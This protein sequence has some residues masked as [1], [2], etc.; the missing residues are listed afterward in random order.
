MSEDVLDTVA[1]A[2]AA[3]FGFADAR[4]ERVTEGLINDTYLVRDAGTG[5]PLAVLQRL[6]PIFAPE[7]HH[8]IDAVTAH[9]AARGLDTPRLLRTRGGEHWVRL[10]GG[11]WRALTYVDGITRSRVENPAQARSAGELVGR[12]HAATADLD[13]AFSFS[14]PG[15]HDTSAHLARLRSAVGESRADELAEARALG[16]AILAR[17]EALPA[18]PELPSRIAHGDLK[19][20]NVVFFRDEPD[21]AR[22]LID[23]DTL[24]RQSIAFE[25][26]DAL[27]SWC[28]GGG[29]D[30]PGRAALDLE[31][32][33]AAL[34]GYAG[35]AGALLSATE[36]D[37]IVPGI[38]TICVE[39]AARFC[40]DAFEDQY[41]GWDPARYPS[42][43]EHNLARARGQLALSRSVNEQREAACKAAR[44]AFAD[45]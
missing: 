31:V 3:A 23:L 15:V 19:I 5:A 37:A 18:L 36:I 13:H 24:T 1:G 35:G 10:E 14:R 9:L 8:D 42:R 25:L 2:A 43:R 39:L 12:F 34:R 44:G 28:N 6:H 11:I 32:L 4:R 38:E 16:A 26:G 30:E 27:R 40:L 17:A 29:E 33:D 7:V 22:C 41:F 21:R 45:A 20:S